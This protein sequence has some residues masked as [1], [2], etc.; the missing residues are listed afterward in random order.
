MQD[1]I[2][3]LRK[4]YPGAP[5]PSAPRVQSGFTFGQ[6]GQSK[7]PKFFTMGSANPPES[8]GQREWSSVSPELKNMYAEAVKNTYSSGMGNRLPRIGE[9]Q[10]REPDELEEENVY[11]QILDQCEVRLEKKSGEA[12]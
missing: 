5:V 12:S 3:A 8:S 9:V 4:P 2:S 1:T 7:I 11:E 10:Q 6:V